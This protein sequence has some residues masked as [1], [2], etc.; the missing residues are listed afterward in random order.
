MQPIDIVGVLGHVIAL[1]HQV[2]NESVGECI[3]S[4][5]SNHL[6]GIVDLLLSDLQI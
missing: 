5:L 2:I 6:N 3:A 1:A 4:S